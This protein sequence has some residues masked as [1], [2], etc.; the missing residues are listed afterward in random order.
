MVA[1]LHK[2]EIVPVFHDS[3]KSSRNAF[4]AAGAKCLIMSFVTPSGP[5]AFLHF[6][7]LIATSI[8][9]MVMGWFMHLSN[10]GCF[11][12][13]DSC[14]LTWLV[15]SLGSLTLLLS[16]YSFARQLAASFWVI[17]SP[18]DCRTVCT[19]SDC[20]HLTALSASTNCKN[21]HVERSWFFHTKQRVS[22]EATVW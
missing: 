6:S 10:V 4:L 7:C 5:G 2:T 18:S 1:F 21:F 3:T 13:W 17:S 8:S 20:L 12:S 14:S 11:Y 19:F 9:V 22:I 16:W 15:L